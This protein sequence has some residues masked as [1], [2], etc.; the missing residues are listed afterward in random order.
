M[1]T[2]LTIGILICTS[3]IGVVVLQASN[4]DSILNFYVFGDSQGY[5]DGIKQ[6]AVV[7]AVH[8]PDFVLHCGDLT[9]FGQE[10][11]YSD[12]KA[13]LD[14]FTVPVYTVI[15]NHDI[16]LGGSQRYISHFGPAHYSFDLGSTHFTVFNSSAGD[17][18]EEELSWLDNDLSSS[19]SQYKIVFSHIPPFDPRPGSNH[20]MTNITTATRLQSIFEENSVDVVFSGHIHMFNET[21][22]NGI[23]YIITGGAGA[24]LYADESEGGIHHFVNVTV[25]DNDI[26]TE[27]VLLETPSWNRNTILVRSSDEDVTLT[28]DSLLDM[29]TVE[30][31]SSFQNQFDN[32]QGQGLYVGVKISELVHLVGGMNEEDLLRV[33]SKDGYQQDFCYWNVFPNSSWFGFQG[34]MVLA[35]ELNE[36]TVPDW[37]DGMRLVMLPEDGTY[38]NQDCLLTSAPGMGYYIYPSAGARWV[39]FV[40]YIEVI[41]N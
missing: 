10:D 41:H 33:V 12:V 13:A 30:Q 40:S 14:E 38:S 19:N 25:T 7:A 5:Q 20:A 34:D 22:V 11:Q 2:I 15:G 8:Q 37:T 39:R 18:L 1:A 35:F 23:R 9:P 28:L 26:I 6:I 3:I 17:I 29:P 32:W 36:T 16:R 24:T 4:N 27:P 21:Q 31:Y